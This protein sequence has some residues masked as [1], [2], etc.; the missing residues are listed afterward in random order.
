MGPIENSGAAMTEDAGLEETVAAAVD[1]SSPV[2]RHRQLYARP[3]QRILDG[4]PQAG[5]RHRPFRHPEFSVVLIWNSK[6]SAPC[7]RNAEG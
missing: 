2:P 7:Q 1:R 4:H 5:A 3:R 6:L